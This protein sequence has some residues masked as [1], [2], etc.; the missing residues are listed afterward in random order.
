MTDH[1]GADEEAR[2]PFITEDVMKK[3]IWFITGPVLM[4]I[5]IVID[6]LTKYLARRD[7]AD[8]AHSLIDGVF[9]LSLVKNKGAAWG[10]LQGR[11]D[12]LSIVSILLVILIGFFFLKIPKEK[13][14]NI[15]RILSIFVIAGA[16]GNVIDRIGFGE[17]TD[18]LYI[19]LIDFPVFNIADCY[20]TFSVVIF[21]FLMLFYYKDEDL[22]FISFKA[23]FG[24][25]RKKEENT[26]DNES[27]DP[28]Q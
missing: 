23:L 18:F 6:Q 27:E 9:S 8:G 12:I 2:L 22:E 13:K 1:N 11:V 28:E 5:L 20:I 25:G 15:I 7:L 17:V 16:I 4:A 24:K 3:K 10:L 26:G 14:Y 21:A 19:E